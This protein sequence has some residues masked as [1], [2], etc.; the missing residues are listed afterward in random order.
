MDKLLPVIFKDSTCKR[1]G[2]FKKRRLNIEH[3]GFIIIIANI[4]LKNKAVVMINVHLV[5]P[6][7]TIV[8]GTL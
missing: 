4:N 3:V 8:G 7:S 5:F 1:F 6:E 2:G